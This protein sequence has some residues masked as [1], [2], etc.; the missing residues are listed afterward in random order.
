[1][2]NLHMLT[3]LK[4]DQKLDLIAFDLKKN[5][6]LFSRIPSQT[7]ADL[8]ELYPEQDVWMFEPDYDDQNEQIVFAAFRLEASDG[9]VFFMRCRLSDTSEVLDWTGP[10]DIQIGWDLLPQELVQAA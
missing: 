9:T 4:K 2:K 10:C 3:N 1:M 6:N 8:L 5:L 7:L